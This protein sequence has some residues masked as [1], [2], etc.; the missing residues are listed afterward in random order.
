[1]ATDNMREEQWK[2]VVTL[3][4][5]AE[6]EGDQYV[7]YCR[8][9]GTSSCGDTAEE[10]LVNLGDAIEVHINALVETGEFLRVFRERNIRIDIPS[11]FSEDVEVSIRVQPKKIFTAYQR[12]VPVLV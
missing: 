7:S 12:P 6:K 10:A 2:G 4:G 5:I 9:L 11:S 3:T 1:M 8:E